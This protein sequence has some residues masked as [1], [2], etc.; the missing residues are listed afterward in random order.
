MLKFKRIDLRVVMDDASIEIELST[1]HGKYVSSDDRYDLARLAL[2][3][4][5]AVID[6]FEKIE[7]EREEP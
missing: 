7:I 3:V 1:V 5:K 2:V 6:E 4:E